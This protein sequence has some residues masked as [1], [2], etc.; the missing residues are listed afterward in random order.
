M[1]G[2][3]D[4]II[5]PTPT[6]VLTMATYKEV[7][8]KF[9]ITVD[10]AHLLKR[11]METTWSV[12]GCDWMSCFEGG[13]DEAY[14]VYGSESAMVAEATIDAGRINSSNP[15]VDLA[16]VTKLPGGSRRGNAIGMAEAVWDARG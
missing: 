15:G 3:W 9:E 13:E 16:W 1:V 4:K 5:S 12:I 8:K 2:W 6:E 11:S 14:E 10:Q 7:A